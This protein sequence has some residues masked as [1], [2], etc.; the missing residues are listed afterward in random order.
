VRTL[1]KELLR[2]LVRDG[3]EYM[4]CM[5]I[6][7]LTMYDTSVFRSP[8]KTCV[9]AVCVWFGLPCSKTVPCCML[10]S[11]VCSC[12]NLPDIIPSI[13]PDPYQ[14]IYAHRYPST[15]LAPKRR[16]GT[17]LYQLTY[18]HRYPSN[19]PRTKEAYWYRSVFE[20]HFSMPAAAETVPGGPR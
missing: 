15:P 16:T 17:D 4:P 9:L 11:Y 10:I 6:Y 14:I 5:T 8:T 19:T 13:V 2:N 1:S 3:Q 18:A 12:F 7:S 20:E